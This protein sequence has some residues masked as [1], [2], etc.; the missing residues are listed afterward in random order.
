MHEMPKRSQLN[1][2]LFSFYINIVYSK[3]HIVHGINI[4]CL[5]TWIFVSD[6]YPTV[7]LEHTD[8]LT[9]DTDTHAHDYLS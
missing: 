9:I 3:L 5:Y 7:T 6:V 1:S 4:A 2:V 8:T